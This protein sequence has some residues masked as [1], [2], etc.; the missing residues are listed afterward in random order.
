MR[1]YQPLKKNSIDI[2]KIDIEGAEK[3][4]FMDNYKT[5]LGKTKVIV[6]ELHDRLDKEISGI[7]F[8]AVNN[9]QTGNI[10]KVRTWFVNFYS[11]CRLIIENE[12]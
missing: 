10:I 7:F 8:K 5:W 11:L 9:Y 1:L 6:I 3:E 4:L 2:L 12:W